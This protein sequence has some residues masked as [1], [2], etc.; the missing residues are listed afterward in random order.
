ME[1][2]EYQLF[3]HPSDRSELRKDI[4]CDDPVA[5]KLTIKKKKYMID[6]A[7]RGLMTRSAS[8]SERQAIADFLASVLAEQLGAKLATATDAEKQAVTRAAWIQAALVL[9]NTSEFLYLH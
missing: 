2:P 6:L 3:I 5:A 9:L 7:Y 8:P 1:V 4:W